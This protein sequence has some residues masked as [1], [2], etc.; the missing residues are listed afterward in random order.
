MW[1]ASWPPY[2][3]RQED[4]T[5]DAMYYLKIK[6]PNT[7]Y[8][9]AQ[10]L[11]ILVSVLVILAILLSFATIFRQLG[12]MAADPSD[13]DALQSFLSTAFTV[14]I[15]IEF[16]KMLSRHNMGSVVEVLL[17]AIS[18]Q[19][20]IEHTS[21]VENLLMVAAIAALFL[22]RKFLFIPGLDDKQTLTV[23]HT[24]EPYEEHV[25]AGK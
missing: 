9:I 20:V 11:E 19:M 23:H 4:T 7:I 13:A 3:D 10:L 12:L 16:L 24:E 5:V 15:G 17:F 6:I 18:R 1:T 8:R 14:V 25:G 2:A 21:P 22:I